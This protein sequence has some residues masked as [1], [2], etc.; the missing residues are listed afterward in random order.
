MAD[1]SPGAA[2]RPDA[3][4]P[5]VYPPLWPPLWRPGE[6]ATPGTRASDRPFPSLSLDEPEAPA[7]PR[8]DA[9]YTEQPHLRAAGHAQA[10]GQVQLSLLERLSL[11]H[12]SAVS[13][14]P[15]TV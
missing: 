7:A 12:L 9:P 13:G 2:N 5:P 10:A 4:Y 8:A 11:A 6:V 14:P 3:L 15:K 1:L